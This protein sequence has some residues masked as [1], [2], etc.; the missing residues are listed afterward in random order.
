MSVVIP[1]GARIPYLNKI[2]YNTTLDFQE[3][4][5]IGVY[6]GENRYVNDNHFLGKLNLLNLPKKKEAEIEVSFRIDANGI[7][8]VSASETSQG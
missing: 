4:M 8:T 5:S 1:K 6:E 7:L 2:K 3:T